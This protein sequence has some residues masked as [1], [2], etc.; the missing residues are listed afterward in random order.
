[1]TR[2]RELPDPKS[3][4]GVPVV[5]WDGQ[6]NFCRTQVQR[7]RWFAG[8][9]RLSYLSL[10]DARV[11]ELCP[12]LSFEQLM[13]QLWLVTP[14]GAKYGGADAGRYLSRILPRLWWLM[15]LLHGGQRVA[16]DDKKQFGGGIFGRELFER[17]DRVADITALDLAIIHDVLLAS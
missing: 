4:P 6:C 3:L 5:I 9:E 14:D 16:A 17:I 8:S 13:E 2:V 1:M 10:H 7:L 11:Q 12:E 15:P